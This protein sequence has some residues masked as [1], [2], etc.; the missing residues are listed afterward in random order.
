GFRTGNAR[1]SCL[2]KGTSRGCVRMESARPMR[3]CARGGIAIINR[4][5]K[6]GDLGKIKNFAGFDE[7]FANDGARVVRIMKAR[8][9]GETDVLG[10]VGNDSYGGGHAFLRAQMH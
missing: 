7:G 1:I 10:R 8:E 2:P 3:W 9:D 4:T 6:F 5:R